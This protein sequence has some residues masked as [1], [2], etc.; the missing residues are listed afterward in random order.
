MATTTEGNAD[1]TRFAQEI[2]RLAEAIRELAHR[3]KTPDSDEDVEQRRLLQRV[4]FGYRALG[5]LMGRVSTGFSAQ[6]DVPVF[7]ARW[8]AKRSEILLPGLPDDAGWIELRTGRRTETVKVRRA[9]DDDPPDADAED[10]REAAQPPRICPT[11]FTRRDPIDS[12]LAMRHRR[13]PVVALGP[14]LAPSPRYAA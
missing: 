2:A 5:T 4:D 7:A 6:F 1:D 12:V 10:G 8:D 11:T 14:R 13:G 9:G 3:P